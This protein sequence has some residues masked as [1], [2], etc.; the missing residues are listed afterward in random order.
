MGWRNGCSDGAD[1]CTIQ[2]PS[3]LVGPLLVTGSVYTVGD[4]L[5]VLGIPIG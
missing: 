1:P 2:S 5:G 3:A 4:A